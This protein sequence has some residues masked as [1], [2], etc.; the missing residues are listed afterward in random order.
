MEGE[1]DRG[2]SLS[3]LAVT[4]LLNPQPSL[5]TLLTC[6]VSAPTLLGC[7]IAAAE[8]HMT[9]RNR[10]NPPRTMGS[11]SHL[12]TARANVAK[13]YLVYYCLKSADVIPELQG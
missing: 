6:T 10:P 3:Y 13:T 9:V 5:G 8:L 12:G 4:D 11:P 1:E 2:P 7:R